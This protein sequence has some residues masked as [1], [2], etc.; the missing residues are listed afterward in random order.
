MGKLQVRVGRKKSRPYFTLDSPENVCLLFI[1][2]LCPESDSQVAAVEQR[3]E[4]GGHDRVAVASGPQRLRGMAASPALTLL[5]QQHF[6][7][8][9]AL[10]S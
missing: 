1:P 4:M 10:E 9:L 8:A 6:S 7:P 5:F 3:T 2:L